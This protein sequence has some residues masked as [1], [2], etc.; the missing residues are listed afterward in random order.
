M[1]DRDIAHVWAHG[2]VWFKVPPS[3]KIIL[4]GIPSE[5]ATP[6]DVVLKMLEKLGANGLL[7]SAAEIYGDYMNSLSLDGRITI[8]SMTTEMGGIILLFP[9]NDEVIDYF[10]NYKKIFFNI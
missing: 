10:K 5:S 3:I 4:N 2:K 9:P 6:K 7:G 8:A 1:G